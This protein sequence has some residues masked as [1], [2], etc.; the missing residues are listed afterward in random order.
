MTSYPSQLMSGTVLAGRYQVGQMLG[1]GTMGTVFEA[2]QMDLRR[3]VAV[4]VLRPE[5]VREPASLERFRREALAAAALGHPNIVQV[6]DF[7]HPQGEP[8]FLVMEKLDGHS[9]EALL[10]R[11][12][13]LA[14]PRVAAIALQVL[15]AL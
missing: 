3:A 5:L 15:S 14:A 10:S 4:K 8:P 2:L 13:M 12:P 11:E 9:L 1:S 6:T 7:Q